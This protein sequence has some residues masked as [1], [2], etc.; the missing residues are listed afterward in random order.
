MATAFARSPPVLLNLISFL[1]VPTL[2][3]LRL[4]CTSVHGLILEYQSTIS[5]RASRSLWHKVPSEPAKYL[6]V[7]SIQDLTRL[8]IARQLAVQVTTSD[9]YSLWDEYYYLGYPEDD[10]TGDALRDR[11]TRGFMLLYQ[12]SMIREAVEQTISL[13]PSASIIERTK[14]ALGNEVMPALKLHE[15]SLRELWVRYT[16]SLDSSDLV[17]FRVMVHC[18]R[19]KL[20][21]DGGLLS[22]DAPFWLPIQESHRDYSPLHWLVGYLMR[23]GPYSIRRLWSQ[24]ISVMV[25]QIQSIRRAYGDRP[26]L[27]SFMLEEHTSW[28]LLV[29]RK[30]KTPRNVG[31]SGTGCRNVDQEALA[32]YESYYHWGPRERQNLDRQQQKEKVAAKEKELE[33]WLNP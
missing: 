10:F 16:S 12:L 1:D 25:G 15:K 17:D 23:H 2:L 6:S 28:R 21:Y 14:T 24:K 27:V 19:G 11:V 8:Y 31:Q 13:Q 29:N 9:Q 7:S 18:V 20:V 30:Y 26:S 33:D 5:R 32:I 3:N 4:L 22:T